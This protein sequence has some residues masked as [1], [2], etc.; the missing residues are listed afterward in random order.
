MGSWPGPVERRQVHFINIFHNNQCLQ[1]SKS[2]L[3]SA[4]NQ[5]AKAGWPDCGDYSSS[6]QSEKT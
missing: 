6:T 1:G 3:L 4:T 2:A 5:K